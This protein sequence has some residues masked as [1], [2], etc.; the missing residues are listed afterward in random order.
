MLL[1]KCIFKKEYITDKM[2]VLEF[3]CNNFEKLYF[4][5]KKI[6]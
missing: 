4:N 2:E 1:T 5:P 6:N 3:S